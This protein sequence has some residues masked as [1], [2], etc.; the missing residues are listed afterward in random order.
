MEQKQPQTFLER[1]QNALAATYGSENIKLDKISARLEAAKKMPLDAN[2]YE[3][4]QEKYVGQIEE[5]YCAVG[6]IRNE[7]QS[8][9]YNDKTAVN[10]AS[11]EN[12]DVLKSRYNSLLKDADGEL[13]ILK[14][15]YNHQTNYGT[16]SCSTSS[17]GKRNRKSSRR[18]RR[19]SRRIRKNHR[20]TSRR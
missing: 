11:Q 8:L 14:R 20:R 6:K 15:M 3:G 16:P 2:Q 17:G 9:K 7:I 13:S 4:Q 12:L 1:A 19:A 10:P 5:K 18:H